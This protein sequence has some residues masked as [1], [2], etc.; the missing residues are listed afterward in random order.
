MNKLIRKIK[1]GTITQMVKELC[2]IVKLSKKYTWAIVWYVFLGMLSIGATL[3][4]SVIS[5]NIIDI[6]T[7]YKTGYAVQ[8]TV[9]YIVMQ[10]T[11]I[12]LS[13]VVSRISIR[14]QIHV[15][16]EL[17]ADIFRKILSAQWEPLSEYHSGDLLSRSSRDID[18]VAGS[19]IS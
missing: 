14:V 10:L 16:Q 19:I 18:T 7:G 3:C 15:S 1:D 13:A 9:I 4:S 5:K 11:S 2:W 17:R 6:V 8:A 12:G